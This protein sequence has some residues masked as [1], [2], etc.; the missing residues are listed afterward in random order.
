MKA[1]LV[2]LALFAGGC[3]VRLPDARECDPAGRGRPVCGLMNPEDVIP[4]PGSRWV[5]ASELRRPGEPP[6]SI[7]AFTLDGDGEATTL[8]GPS[9]PAEWLDDPFLAKNK[10]ICPGP[11]PADGLE[12]HGMDLVVEREPPW[13]LLVVN[14]GTRE[15]IEIYDVTPSK[16]DDVAPRLRWMGCIP[17]PDGYAA[18]DVAAMDDGQLVA[19]ATPVRG[20]DYALAI[21]RMAVGA[22]LGDAMEWSFDRG[23]HHVA[24]TRVGLPNGVAVDAT[25]RLFVA[26]WAGSRL[27]RVDRATGRRDEIA[28]PHHPD[29]L[30][31]APDGRL[32]VAGQIGTVREAFGC[33][34]GH[35]RN[36]GQPWSV[37]SV[38]PETMAVVMIAQGDGHDFGAASSAAFAQ[39]T[40][41]VGTWAGDRALRL[42][43]R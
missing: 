2:A 18:N 3:A 33:L 30:S 13:M 5:L 29:N 15:S 10:E 37:L 19:S 1:L 38:D 17:L 25:G 31:W 9:A 42:P 36:C 34:D 24:H 41:V 14:H 22:A 32:V 26:D 11:L 27:V 43:A 4:L 20:I 8:V 28:L 40:L 6:G 16:H 23:W 39:E 7:V 35:V 12:P 21:F